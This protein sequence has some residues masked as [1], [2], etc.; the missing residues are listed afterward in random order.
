MKLHFIIFFIL[1]W[2]TP[3]EKKK[4]IFVH[5]NKSIKHPRLALVELFFDSVLILGLSYQLFTVGL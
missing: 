1:E 4:S 2:N 3:P 5:L